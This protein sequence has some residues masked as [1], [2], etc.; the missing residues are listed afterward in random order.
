MQQVILEDDEID[1]REY[2]HVILKYKWSILG[3]TFVIALLTV[4][5]LF[6]IVPTYQATATLLIESQQENVVSIEE[7]YGLQ[8]GNDEHIQTQNQ[9]L[10]S[11][12]LAE[13]VINELGL[14][15]HPEFDPTIEKAGLK[16]DPRSWIPKSWSS[17]PDKPVTEQAI[18]NAI[19]ETFFSNLTV[20]LIRNSQLITVSFDANDPAL[21]EKVPNALANAYIESDLESR[22]G[23]TEKAAEWITERLDN[24]RVNLEASDKALQAFLERENLVDVQGIDSL[25]SMELDEITREMTEV[26]R[27][28]TEAEELFRQ[29]KALQGQSSTAYESIPA[30]LDDLNVQSAKQ[31]QA[32]ANRKVS[33]LS[34]RYGP[35]HPKMIAAVNELDTA[36][37]HVATQVM[38]VIAS[39]ENQYQLAIAKERELNRSLEQT[40]GT[41]S[42]LNRQENSLR[43]LERDVQ[44]NRQLYDMFLTRYKETNVVGDLQT[45]SARVVDKATLPTEPYKPKKSLILLISIFIS[46]TAGIILAFLKES[47]DNTLSDT[48]DME[49]RLHMPVLGILP[50]MQGWLKKNKHPIKDYTDEVQPGFSENVRT[51]RTGLLLSGLDEPKKIILVTSSVPGE[52]KSLMSVNMALSLGQMGKVL[53]IDAD[54]RRPSIAGIFGLEKGGNGL[55]Q[56]VA[57]TATLEESMH[58]YED[59]K[60]YVMSAGIIPPNPLELLSS[61]RFKQGLKVLIDKFDHIVIDSA[62]TIAVAD[63]TVISQHVNSLIY[64]VKADETPYQLAQ[65]G[66][67]R[68]KH[69]NAPFTGVV[70]N[71]VKPSNKPGK[72]GYYGGDYYKYYGYSDA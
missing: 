38:N 40:K 48:A 2:L 14:A 62:P 15:K 52:G 70:L 72:Y 5:V 23:M 44:S 69:V 11:R 37:T 17:D 24:L 18:Q 58:H 25:T 53:L 31:L 60:L 63:A 66:I 54:M 4:L 64:M 59:M 6:S 56:F 13:R 29:S 67:K 3:L 47:L 57:G 20:S 36:D 43:A 50:V 8:G 68:L 22:L 42:D 61:N 32:E 46:M 21:A 16:L 49:N 19:V 7:V 30:V 35:K 34:K 27:T 9:I 39:V 1:L 12:E 65:E 45:A 33:E 71:Q 10:Q 28:R 41:M 26:R 55:S 51:I